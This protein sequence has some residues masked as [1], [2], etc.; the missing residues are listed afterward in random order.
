[1]K[2]KTGEGCQETIAKTVEIVK[3]LVETMHLIEKN[4]DNSGPSPA[5][6]VDRYFR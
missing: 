4:N 3:L 5:A 2:I 6:C 1:M